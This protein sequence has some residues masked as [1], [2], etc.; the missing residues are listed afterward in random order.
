M[1]KGRDF[2]VF[3]L[4]QWEDFNI[5]RSTS[6]EISR[7]N[8]VLF[9]NVPLYRSNWLRGRNNPEFQKRFD[10]L[11]NKAPEI[12]KISESIWL[13]NPRIVLES[14]NWIN[15]PCLFDYFN[16]INDKRLAKR[17]KHAMNE[18]GF[19]DVIVLND[20]S[21]IIGYYL[22]ELLNPDLYIYLLRDAVTLVP[23]HAKHGTR[24]EPKLIAKSDL[25]VTNSPFF[26]NFKAKH[27]PESYYVGQGCNPDLY[28]DPDGKLPLPEDTVSLKR[29]II[30]YVGMLTSLRLDI[31][32]LVEMAEKRPDWTLLLVGPED[33]D[34]KKSRL[35]QMQNVVFLGK[36]PIKEVPAYMK[37][38]DIAIN[39]Q[40]VNKITD[41][42]YPL[43]T[44]E[45]LAMGK[46][47][48]A[49]KTT[50]MEFYFKDSTYLATGSDEYITCIEKALKE[51]SAELAKERKAVAQSHSWEHFVNR[52]FEPA[53]KIM[54]ERSSK[55]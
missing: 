14:I 25:M 37:S 16:K 11:S 2:V 52:I 36:K 19:H 54:K 44:D 50:F 28:S 9:V 32:L 10:V 1:I 47:A 3:S 29:P 46:P 42:N 21:M 51:D 31:Q 35:H 43:K 4:H 23:Y 22:K 20:T 24:L 18:L 53:I 15:S 26:D 39:P 30:G 41:L 6:L 38:F 27:N 8:R 55:Q 5:S 45:Y 40:I 33:D 48:V 49:T 34:F 12:E 17:I 13:M 7:N